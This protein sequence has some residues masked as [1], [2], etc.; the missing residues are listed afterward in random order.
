LPSV[1]YVIT[2]DTDTKLPR[3]AARRLVG[4][5]AHPL[6]RRSLIRKGIVCEGYSILQPRVGVSVLSA[7][8]SWFVRLFAGEAGIDPYTRAVSDVYQDVFN[9]GSFIGKGIY[10]VDAFERS[11]RGRFPENTVL[12]HDLIE[13]VHARS[14]L[15]SDVELYEEHPSRYNADINRRHRWIR[16]DWQ[17]A[18]WVL[19][20]VR[21]PVARRIAN[22]LSGLSLWKIFDNLRRSL[23]PA[24][25]TLLLLGSWILLPELRGIGPLVVL[26]IITIPGLLSVL[27]E[28]LRKPAEWPWGM[29]LRWVAKSFGHQFGQIALTLVF[30]PYD[31]YISLDAIGRTL[32]RLFFTRTRL[33]EWQT[34]SEAERNARTDLRSFYATMWI[35]P[36]LALLTLFYLLLRQPDHLPIAA[37]ILVLWLG[38]PWIAWWI[39]RPIEPAAPELT[40]GQLAFLRT[41]ARK[42]WR[43]FETF[44]TAQDNWLPPDNFQEQPAPV[45]ALRT[46]PT[47]MGLALLANLAASDFGYLS[48]GQLIERTQKTVATMQRLERTA[49][50]STTGMTR[51]S[52]LYC[53]IIFPLWTA[54]ISPAFADLERGING[55]PDQKIIGPQTFMGLRDTAG[56]LR[57]LAG[58][59]SLV[60]NINRTLAN[61]PPATLRDAFALLQRVK[62]EASQLV[63]ALDGVEQEL[64]W[65]SRAFERNCREH[66]DDLLF[67][68]PW[69]P[70]VSESKLTA[71]EFVGAKEKGERKAKASSPNGSP[72]KQSSMPATENPPSAAEVVRKYSNNSNGFHAPRNRPVKSISMRLCGRAPS[73]A[74]SGRRS[75]HLNEPA[76]G[77][78]PGCA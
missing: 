51:R 27:V 48:V 45:T 31:A 72:H 40:P 22:P 10:D 42:T 11:V 37:P 2:L 32:V 77:I 53:H 46:S 56:I 60:K 5:I 23:V 43:F 71:S 62:L 50:I 55:V 36:V 61:P 15:V 52:S 25:L 26:A 13:S 67:L 18:Q 8:R 66:L 57:E 44:V 9:E 41:I 47:N 69:L 24:A 78:A 39:S 59:N 30:L 7:G 73:G 74:P 75:S 4:T 29:P 16:G 70:V 34:A 33:L 68:V 54:A 17:I 20:R 3:D 19:P 63:A 12:S 14:G 38:A 64:K 21:G 76:C 1:K 35:E 6:N 49:D 58:E 28:A 65:W